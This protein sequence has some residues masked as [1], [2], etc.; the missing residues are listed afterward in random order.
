MDVKKLFLTIWAVLFSCRKFW[1]D[2][3][4]GAPGIGANVLKEYSV[5]VIAMVQL[6]KF[7]VIG[8]P[9]QA[10]ITA[11]A[12]FLADMAA[13]Y[14]L[15]GGTMRLLDRENRND[16]EESV[17]ALT[18]FSLT[19]LW[20]VEPLCFIDG[21]NWLFSAAAIVYAMLLWRCGFFL[22][23]ERKA[24]PAGSALRNSSILLVAVSAAVFLLEKGMFRLFKGFPV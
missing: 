13:I 23:L 18:G 11:I 10:M 5:P 2:F 14:L 15:A 21:W 19:P 1:T 17:T 6:V 8:T 7:P 24:P 4:A 16:I 3:R 20:L 12:S 22:L 9:R